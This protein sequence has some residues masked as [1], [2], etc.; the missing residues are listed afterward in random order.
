MKK[1]GLDIKQVVL[2]Q[3]GGPFDSG[4]KWASGTGVG[5]Y[6]EGS[7]MAV[8]VSANFDFTPTTIIVAPQNSAPTIAI[9]STDFSNA[10]FNTVCNKGWSANFSKYNESRISKTGFTVKVCI[11]K[12]YGMDNILYNWIAFGQ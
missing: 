3:L 5:N 8:T 6:V 7:D 10:G 9:Y 12:N 2:G 1:D 11:S 4:K